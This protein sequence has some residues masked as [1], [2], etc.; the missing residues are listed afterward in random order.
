MMFFLAADQ[1][2]HG[3]LSIGSATTFLLY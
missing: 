2:K 3:F 1:V